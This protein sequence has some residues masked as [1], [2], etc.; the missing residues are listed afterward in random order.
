MGDKICYFG[1]SNSRNCADHMR[2]KNNRD[3]RRSRSR[4]KSRDP[5]P[6]EIKAPDDFSRGGAKFYDKTEKNIEQQFNRFLSD[7]SN[8]LLGVTIS[9]FTLDI[10]DEIWYNKWF[11]LND[12]DKHTDKGRD[13]IIDKM[14]RFVNKCFK[15]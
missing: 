2:R 10:S 13:I 12:N 3:S 4:S 11:D 9:P 1:N 15:S 7:E 5:A 14:D 6:L 8:F